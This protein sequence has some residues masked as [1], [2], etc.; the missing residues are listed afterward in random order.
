M[1]R[2]DLKHERPL[3]NVGNKVLRYNRRRDTRMG[4]KLAPRFSGPYLIDAVL[5]RGV[6]RLRQGD[7]VLKKTVNASNLKMF[8][9]EELPQSMGSTPHK[10]SSVGGSSTTP[11]SSTT[12]PPKKKNRR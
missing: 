8:I 4:D 9:E 2:Y 10:S 7:T 12:S 11:T 1:H 5:G 6:Y 3:Y